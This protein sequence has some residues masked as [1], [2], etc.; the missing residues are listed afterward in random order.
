MVPCLLF[1]IHEQ[2]RFNCWFDWAVIVGF[3]PGWCCD[4]SAGFSFIQTSKRY[5]KIS[6][7]G[8]L[9]I[10][11]SDDNDK[12]AVKTK[13][14]NIIEKKFE[15]KC[16]EESSNNLRSCEDLSLKPASV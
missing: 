10:E 5:E 7:S 2:L 3:N 11:L 14:K 6:L 4:K 13:H 9:F 12:P 16:F 8:T 15:N 1:W